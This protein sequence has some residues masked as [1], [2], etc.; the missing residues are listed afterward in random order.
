MSAGAQASAEVV[1]AGGGTVGVTLALALKRAVPNLDVVVV[2]PERPPSAEDARASAIAAAARRMLEQLGVWSVL[3]PQAQPI[4]EMVITDSRTGDAVRPVFLTFEGTVDGEPF[5]H[6]VPNSG[7]ALALRS[8]A[9]RA[10]VRFLA[11]AVSDFE[12]GAAAARVRFRTGSLIA[13]NLLV[14]AD[15]AASPLRALAGIATTELHYGQ[16]GIVATVAH[17]R[18]HNGRAEEHFLPGGPF[19]ILP[20]TENR[21]SLV[22]TEPSGDAARLMEM[23]GAD[24]QSELERRFGHRLGAVTLVGGR[25]SYPLGLTMARNLVKPRFAL[26]GDAAHSIHPIA[27]Q[28]LNLGFKDVAA[29][30]ETIV[31]AR[32]LGL[33]PGSLAVLERYERWRRADMLVMGAVT[34]TLNRLF[35]NDVG[36]LRAIRDVG[37]GLVDRMPDLK[38]FFMR[39]AAGAAGDLPRLLRGEPI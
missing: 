27:G 15:G 30:A 11:D 34:D 8:G 35:S 24:F 19:A 29:L 12:V 37:L 18:P 14:A 3:A 17:A 32:R 28:G 38:R 31:E 25:W 23:S 39:Q 10:G 33:D 7:L 16:S 2:D 6:M 4:N 5:A 21:A 26:A 22:W 20:L 1:I 13:A 9:A 36:P